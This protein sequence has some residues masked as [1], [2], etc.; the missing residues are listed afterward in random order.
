MAEFFYGVIEGFYGR[1]WS[2]QARL[3]Y[4]DFF[5]QYGFK[6]YIYA[7]KGDRSLRKDW[8]SEQ[9]EGHWHKLLELSRHYQKSGLRW[10][11]GFSPGGLAENYTATE[12][13]L[14]QA[15]VRRINQLKPNILCILFDDMRGDIEGLAETQLAIVADIAAASDAEHFIVCPSYYSF[16]PVLEE[17]FGAMPGNY[18]Q[19]LG[20]N[21]PD[22]F[23]FFWTG[24][25]VI[26]HSFQQSDLEKIAEAFRRKPLLWDNYPVND[27][28]KTS[29][30]LFL[31]PFE[32]RPWQLRDWAAGHLA[33]PMNQSQLSKWVLQS[34]AAVYRQRS[35][36]QS[37]ASLTAVLSSIS[38]RGFAQQ[39][40][41]DIEVFANSGLAFFSEQQRVEMS[42]MYRGFDTPE[43]TE[44][45]DWL[46][47]QYAFDPAC[48]T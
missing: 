24:N 4:A 23:D 30:H 46:E 28:R 7:P 17:V 18:W 11:L 15:K 9:G 40:S 39:L 48:L 26:S 12:K 31:K 44:I 19:T 32:G 16:D 21:L 35:G 25:R 34:L 47:G 13:A 36:Y 27:G 20:E 22:D 41:K 2:H 45:A 3:D 42:L 6:A 33:N 5:N 29:Q 10:G 38:H 8:R 14:L 37:A 1:Q 43:S